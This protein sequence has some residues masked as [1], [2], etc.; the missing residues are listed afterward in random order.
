MATQG[1]ASHGGR[2]TMRR[3]RHLCVSLVAAEEAQ[4]A[5]AAV[6][7][8]LAKLRDATS[9]ADYVVSEHLP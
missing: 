5:E 7:S 6:E 1:R 2:A 8:P 3:L 9:E 4:A